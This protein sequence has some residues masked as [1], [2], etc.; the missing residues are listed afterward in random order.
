MTYPKNRLADACD[1]AIATHPAIGVL[2][3]NGGAPVFYAMIEQPA[4][5][6]L[7]ERRRY[8]MVQSEDIGEVLAQVQ[9]G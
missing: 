7:G 3:G 5:G 2:A 6:R 8:T 1:L 9:H 4:T